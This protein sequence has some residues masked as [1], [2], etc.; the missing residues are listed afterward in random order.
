MF[1]PDPI[2]RPSGSPASSTPLADYLSW[3]RYGTDDD[4]TVLPRSLAESMPLPWQQ[5]MRDLLAEFHRAFGH[6]QWPVY[7][8]VPSGYERLT[9]LDEQQLSEIGCTMEL[10]DNGEP[11]YRLRDG[12]RVE[13]PEER[14][15]LVPRPDPIPSRHA[16]SEG[17]SASPAPPNW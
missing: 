6:L 3:T 11:E 9:E 12:S 17:P 8:V 15:F 7:R 5:H 14:R 16:G 1:T 4:Y 13:S 10:G 2:P